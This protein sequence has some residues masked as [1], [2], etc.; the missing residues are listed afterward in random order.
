M[1][2]LILTGK[3]LLSLFLVCFLIAG[4]MKAHPKTHNP[5]LRPLAEYAAGFLICFASCLG[6]Y[7]LWR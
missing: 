6:L 1:A 4:V 7:Y 5:E 3:L 2:L